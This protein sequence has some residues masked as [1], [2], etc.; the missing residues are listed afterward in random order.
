MA[1]FRDLKRGRGRYC[2]WECS[3]RGR[4]RITAIVAAATVEKPGHAPTNQVVESFTLPLK[5]Y[6]I[7][8]S[9]LRNGNTM[10]FSDTPTAAALPEVAAAY[11]AIE[12]IVLAH[13]SAGVKV[14]SPAYLKGLAEILH[15]V[16]RT[17]AATIWGYETH[18]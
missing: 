12:N 6:N 9:K 2:S 17:G 15:L 1:R 11:K 3:N 18:E 10:V 8:I 16:C 14:L 5:P 13:H 4:G 7:T